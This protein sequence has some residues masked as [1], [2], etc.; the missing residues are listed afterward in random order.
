MTNFIIGLTVG[1]AASIIIFLLYRKLWEKQTQSSFG[2][3][4]PKIMDLA[5]RELGQVREEINKDVVKEKGMIKESLETIEKNLKDRQDE[6][7]NLATESH[8]QFGTISESIKIHKEVAEKL[9]ARTDN[10]GKILSNNKLRGDWGE[11]IAE[12]ILRYAGFIEEVHYQ[13]QTAGET[14]SRPD[15]TLLL[16]NKRKI[17]IDA[18]FPFNNLQAFQEAESEGLKKEYLQ[19]FT[20]DVKQKIREVSTRDYI[21]EEEDTL[22][23]VIL[24]VPSE[25][26][27]GFINDQL[28]DVVDEAFQKKVLFTSPTSLYATL[29]IIMES[30]RHFMYEKNIKEVLKIVQGFIVN[31]GRFS[32]EFSAFDDTIKKLRQNFDQIA[33]T[34]YKKMA[35]QIRQI[36][37]LEGSGK[38]VEDGNKELG[39]R[40]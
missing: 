40:N 24:F 17:N 31:F 33:D 23:Y 39:I 9:S 28:R 6:L 35:V 30:Y 11:R 26:V 12:D 22:D 37:K 27:Y 32:E 16:P 5:R 7:K 1:L 19:K 34:R 14:G 2:E 20:A 8:R 15:F 38:E 3:M 4:I 18:K 13:R 25:V 10:L 29:R 21:N 36:Q